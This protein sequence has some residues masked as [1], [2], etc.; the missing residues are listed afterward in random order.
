MKISRQARQTARKLYAI[1]LQPQGGIDESRVRAVLAY[2]QE[3]RPRH[4]L[5]ILTRLRKLLELEQA[6]H[7]TRVE[8]ATALDADEKNALEAALRN[9]FGTMPTLEFSENP[10]LLGGLRI[11]R[12]STVWDGSIRGRLRQ[13]QQ[14]FK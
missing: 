7:A 6:R 3:N 11:Q 4:S 1:C 5:G 12:G 10:S 13:L 14:Q 9:V 2:V 8:A